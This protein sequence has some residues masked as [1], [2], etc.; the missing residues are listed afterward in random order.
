MGIMK[1]AFHITIILFILFACISKEN[2]IKNKFIKIIEKELKLIQQEEIQKRDNPK[3]E[4][5]SSLFEE[6]YYSAY[7]YDFKEYE[8]NI[9]KTDSIVSPYIAT[10]TFNGIAYVKKGKTLQDC[11]NN[12]WKMRGEEEFQETKGG[13]DLL[14]RYI[15]Y[16]QKFAYQD[17]EW[18]LK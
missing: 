14:Q 12:D 8:Y 13:L 7:Y 10:V 4:L 3:C 11:L 17:G 18:V 5:K 1:R 2:K 16:K 9:K 15:Y 6:N